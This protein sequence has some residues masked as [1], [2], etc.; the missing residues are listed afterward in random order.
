MAPAPEPTAATLDRITT[1]LRGVE[2]RVAQLEDAISV[3]GP[4]DRRPWL[5]V[6]P[7]RVAL[8]HKQTTVMV[9]GVLLFGIGLYTWAKFRAGEDL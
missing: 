3:Y 4:P 5:S 2:A 7:P 6:H 1:A 9:Y 8:S